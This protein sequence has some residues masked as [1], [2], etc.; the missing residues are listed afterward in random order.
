MAT[1]SN[2]MRRVHVKCSC[3]SPGVCSAE[4]NTTN[5]FTKPLCQ[6]KPLI[7]WLSCWRPWMRPAGTTVGRRVFISHIPYRCNSLVRQAVLNTDND[8]WYCSYALIW[9][10]SCHTGQTHT[11][12]TV[13]HCCSQHSTMWMGWTVNASRCPNSTQFI[14]QKMRW[15]ETRQNIRSPCVVKGNGAPHAALRMWRCTQ[16]ESQIIIIPDILLS[17]IVHNT[18]WRVYWTTLIYSEIIL[19]L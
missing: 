8:R 11:P 6:I 12:P 18:D 4:E 7:K 9:C 19:W 5:T 3:S 13:C 10:R 14:T 16:S 2:Q 15:T 1:K 17:S